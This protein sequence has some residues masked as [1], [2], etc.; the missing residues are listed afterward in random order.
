M[1]D[2]NVFLRYFKECWKKHDIHNRHKNTIEA[3]GCFS[4]SAFFN[5]LCLPSC[6]TEQKKNSKHVWTKMLMCPIHFNCSG[7]ILRKSMWDK[8][9]W[10]IL[11][12]V[13]KNWHPY[14]FLPTMEVNVFFFSS[15]FFNTSS[16][17]F[18]SIKT[19]KHVWNWKFML[20]SNFC[21]SYLEEC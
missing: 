17:V 12:N 13:G 20:P 5:A 10:D 6:S 15:T 16:L 8:K 11:K 18:N 4:P 9:N 3:N 19:P 1:R 14:I 2:E 7:R 21:C